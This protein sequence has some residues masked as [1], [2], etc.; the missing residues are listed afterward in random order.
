M[1]EEL[2]EH[3]DDCR[4]SA[5]RH[6]LPG[7][8]GVD[9]LETHW[10]ESSESLLHQFGAAVEQL[11]RPLKLRHYPRLKSLLVPYPPGE[12]ACWPVSA[13]VGRCAT[14]TPV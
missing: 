10:G 9:F 14:M 13:R 2:F 12:M 11:P 5:R 7:A 4:G 3:M 1:L 6:A 8:P